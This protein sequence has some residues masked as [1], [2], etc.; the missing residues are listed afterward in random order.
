MKS[1]GTR[2]RWSARV[3]GFVLLAVTSLRMEAVELARES[4]Y[5]IAAQS[6][7]AALIQFSQQANLQI[8]T[9]GRSLIGVQSKGVSGN[10]SVAQALDQLLE[11]TGFSYK[12]VGEGTI[13]VIASPPPSRRA[14]S[15]DRSNSGAML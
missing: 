2:F 13:S 10:Y 1:D 12:P 11:G 15:V 6:L 14:K 4:S 8:V 9:S 5:E 7:P 3:V